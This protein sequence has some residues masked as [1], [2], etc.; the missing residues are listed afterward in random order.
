MLIVLENGRRSPQRLTRFTAPRIRGRDSVD[1]LTEM[2][3]IRELFA[4]QAVR[5]LLAEMDAEIMRNLLAVARAT[6]ADNT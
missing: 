4:E 2:P 3:S 1:L 6:N 5:E